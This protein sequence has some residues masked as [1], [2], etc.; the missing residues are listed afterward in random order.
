MGHSPESELVSRPPFCTHLA[1]EQALLYWLCSS[2]WQALECSQSA[3]VYFFLAVFCR[4]I[5]VDLSLVSSC[6]ADCHCPLAPT[7]Y[8]SP[9]RLLRSALKGSQCFP[10]RPPSDLPSFHP[11][12]SQSFQES[13]T[14]C[15]TWR[16]FQLCTEMWWLQV[17]IADAGVG[18]SYP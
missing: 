14:S 1:R 6:N 12:S 7:S 13:L 5:H 10:E 4:L 17:L 9:T 16:L 2:L 3:H 8:P 11:V 15:D 18:L